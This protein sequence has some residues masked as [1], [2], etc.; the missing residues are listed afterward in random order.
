MSTRNDDGR[1]TDEAAAPLNQEPGTAAP[2]DKAAPNPSQDRERANEEFG[3]TGPDEM[4]G[5]GQGA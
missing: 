2:R 4:P 1:P 3:N 5:F